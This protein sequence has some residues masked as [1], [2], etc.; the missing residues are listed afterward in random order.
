MSKIIFTDIDGVVLTW[1]TPFHTYMQ[2]HGHQKVNC[3]PV[4]WKQSYYPHLS[5]EE[6]IKM[7]YHFNTSAWMLGLPA[8]KDAEK[9][10]ARLVA[11]GYKFVGVTAMG[12]DP[13][14]LDARVI[15][16]ERMFGE[17]VFIDII[18]TD[19]YDPDS[20]RSFLSTHRDKGHYWIEDKPFNAELGS[21]LGFDTLLIE[22]DYNKDYVPTNN[23]RSVKSW[24]AICDIILGS[25]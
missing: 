10:V 2:S 15:N 16:L 21:E 8:Y 22:H 5:N 19:M 3:E 6:V 20:K 17:D 7:V 23:M 14:A 24:A 11:E 4:Y 18:A 1:D 25:N 12:V 9:G 13:H